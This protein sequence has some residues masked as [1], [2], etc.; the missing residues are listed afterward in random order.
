MTYLD[1]TDEWDVRC[2]KCGAVEGRP[3]VY[4]WPESTTEWTKRHSTSKTAVMIRKR[5]G[6]VTDR[7]HNERP[8][9]HR[10]TTLLNML[11]NTEA[12]LPIINMFEEMEK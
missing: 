2:P 5:V 4:T 12:W 6:T 3:C 10:G 1:V 9:M 11:F 8:V 7:V